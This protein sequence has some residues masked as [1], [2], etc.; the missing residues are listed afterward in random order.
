[1]NTERFELDRVE[2]YTVH[3]VDGGVVRIPDARAAHAFVES[4]DEGTV[5]RLFEA[6]AARGR[7]GIMLAIAVRALERIASRV[8]I[9]M[10]RKGG[11][12]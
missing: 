12:R 8:L 3:D 6:C 7:P 10:V 11:E 1:M 4:L 2:P 9:G 5:E